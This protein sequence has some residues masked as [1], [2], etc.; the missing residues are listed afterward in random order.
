MRRWVIAVTAVAAVAAMIA[1]GR[2]GGGDSARPRG[3]VPE[4]MVVRPRRREMVRSISLTGDVVGIQQSELMA[5]VPGFIEAIYVDR[6][7]FV[8]RDQLLARLSYPEQEAAYARAMAALDLAEANYQRATKL[9]ERGVNSRQDLDNAVANY[10]SAK[11][12]MAAERTLYGYREIR[13]PFAGYI[14]RRN[15]DT[16]HLVTPAS[17]SSTAP[18][19]ILADISTVR[20]FVYVPEEDLGALRTGTSAAVSSDAYPGR[21]FRGEVRRIA[22]GLDTATRTMQTEID[23]VNPEA[24]L[25]PGMFAR[26]TLVLFRHRNALVLPPGAILR[27]EEGNYVYTVSGDRAHHVRVKTGLQDGAAVEIT[28]GLD[29]RALVIAS[30]SESV[31]EDSPIR[32]AGIS[33]EA[34]AP[35][36]DGR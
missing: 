9:F 8:K 25:K 5:K 4:V 11:D 21:I 34:E 15:Y 2:R 12:S 27:G 26:V 31:E 30:G 32:I 18:L 3:R 16:G 14:I 20:V 23:I 33:S 19:F 29:D 17:D 10:K 35:L 1:W 13:A 24:E 7:D 36:A 28:S 6:G 22:Q